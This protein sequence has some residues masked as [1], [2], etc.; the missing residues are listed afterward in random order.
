MAASD[1]TPPTEHPLMDKVRRFPTTPGV[2]LMKDDRGVVL[3]VGKAASLRSRV[4]S[5]FQPSAD[6]D[7]RK[8]QMVEQVVDVDFLDCETEAEAMLTEARLIKDIQPKYNV[9]LTDDKTFPYLEI[10]VREDF[11][12]VYITRSPQARGTRLYGPFTNVAAL[13]ESLSH[14]QKAFKFRTC[15]LE[16][17]SDDESRRHFRP[18]LLHAIK[19]CTAPCADRI[20]RDDYRRDIKRLQRFFESRRSVVLRQLEKEMADAS[21]GLEFERAA[22]LRDQI[23]ALEGLAERGQPDE[24]VQPELFYQDPRRGLT[25]LARVLDLPEAP[26]TIEGFDIATLQGG[27]SVGSAVFFLDGVP[28]KNRYRRFRIKTVSGVDDFASLREI[29]ARHYRQAGQGQALFPDVILIDGGPGQLSS[30]MEALSE[31]ARRP[32]TVISLAK[33]EEEIYLPTQREPIRLGRNNPALQLLQQVRDEAHRFAQHYHHI[34]RRKAI[35]DEDVKQG[36][37]PPGRRRKDA[38]ARPEPGKE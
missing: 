28:F 38:D 21:A 18:C 19:Q 34:L 25:S 16:I 14:L 4:S 2:Y 29:V 3:Y 6:L 7:P 13:R 27:Q 33:R 26:R 5:Y 23:K 36:R 1:A 9:R 24:H 35:F 32:A 11:P 17:D 22:R 31:M 15:H 12:G 10:T 30:V 37:R 20:S 8:R